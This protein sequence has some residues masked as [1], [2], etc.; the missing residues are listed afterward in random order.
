MILCLGVTGSGKTMLLHSLKERSALLLEGS[1]PEVVDPDEVPEF[2]IPVPL[3][4]SVAT[5]GTDLIKLSRPSTKRN[6]PPEGLMGLVLLV[7]FSLLE[8]QGCQTLEQPL[9]VPMH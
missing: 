4:P 2:P 6:C 1:V 3:L 7:Q 5:V 8:A 9:E